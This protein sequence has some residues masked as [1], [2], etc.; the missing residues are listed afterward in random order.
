MMI[1][2]EPMS[3][4][5]FRSVLL[6]I[7]LTVFIHIQPWKQHPSYFPFPAEVY[8]I[9]K[10]GARTVRPVIAWPA[11]SFLNETGRFCKNLIHSPSHSPLTGGSDLLIRIRSSKLGTL[12]IA[13]AM[14][15]GAFPLNHFPSG[16]KV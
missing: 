14:R 10:T 9:H 12:F 16:S 11:N 1:G 8:F 15:M 7:T 2:P 6:G 4:I 5:R 3:I 13:R